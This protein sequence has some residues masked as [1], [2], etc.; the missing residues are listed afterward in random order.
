MAVPDTQP[1]ESTPR[2][3]PPKPQPAAA[4]ARPQNGDLTTDQLLARPPGGPAEGWQAVV[5]Q[6]SGV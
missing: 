4:K 1:P 3:D 5:Y 6:L 2:P